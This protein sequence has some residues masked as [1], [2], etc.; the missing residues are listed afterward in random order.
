[1]IRVTKKKRAIAVLGRKEKL[2]RNVGKENKRKGEK[3]KEEVRGIMGP[4]S[5]P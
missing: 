5:G 3:T 2:R 1:M 4:R